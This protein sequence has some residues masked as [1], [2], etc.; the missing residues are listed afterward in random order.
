MKKEI[1]DVKV[2]YSKKSEVN[3]FSSDFKRHLTNALPVIEKS[4]IKDILTIDNNI[5]DVNIKNFEK[6]TSYKDTL[7]SKE[8]TLLSHFV[9]ATRNILG[10][11]RVNLIEKLDNYKI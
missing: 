7:V 10:L 1:K 5:I 3:Y 6:L 8:K 9:T 4:Q 11:N 2:S